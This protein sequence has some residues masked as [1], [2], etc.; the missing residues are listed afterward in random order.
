M[1]KPTI[2]NSYYKWLKN[3]IGDDIK[4]ATGS[5]DLKDPNLYIN[6]VFPK[7]LKGLDDKTLLSMPDDFPIDPI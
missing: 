2:E 6:L 3:L 7:D 1:T 4:G 5:F